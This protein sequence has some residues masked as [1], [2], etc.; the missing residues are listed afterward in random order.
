MAALEASG[1]PRFAILEKRQEFRW[2]IRPYGEQGIIL[3]I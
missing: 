3:Y 2:A 1:S